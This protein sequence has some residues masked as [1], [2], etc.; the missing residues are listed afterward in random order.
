MKETDKS[1]NEPLGGS[2]YQKALERAIAEAIKGSS[3]RWRTPEGI[4]ADILRARDP[5]KAVL[6][7]KEVLRHE[8]DSNLAVAVAEVLNNSP[9][10][11]RSTSL[12]ETG[13][14]LYAVRKDYTRKAG[15]LSQLASGILGVTI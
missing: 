7:N 11:L 14:P 15:F 3:Y 2:G 1:P 12:S 13:S 10:F 4:T 9:T 6:V 8:E 5:V